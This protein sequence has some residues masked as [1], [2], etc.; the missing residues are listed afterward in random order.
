MHKRCCHATR[1]A[2]RPLSEWWLVGKLW[3]LCQLETRLISHIQK[4]SQ[5][6]EHF[7]PFKGSPGSHSQSVSCSVGIYSSRLLL[8]FH[9]FVASAPRYLALIMLLDYYKPVLKATVDQNKVAWQQCTVCDVIIVYMI[10]VSVDAQTNQ[11]TWKQC[12]HM[13]IDSR[14]NRGCLQSS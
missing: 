4:T 3:E 10:Q 2:M 13:L 5:A 14:T 1:V 7:N 8:A 6:I 12:R 9:I 11:Q